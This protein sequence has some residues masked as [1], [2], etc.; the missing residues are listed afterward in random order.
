LLNDVQ[1]V[2]N[3]MQASNNLFIESSISFR[4]K[5]RQPKLPFLFVTQA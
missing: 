5:K 3:A 1:D 2:N 4:H